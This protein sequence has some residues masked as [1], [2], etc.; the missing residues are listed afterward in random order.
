MTARPT[1]IAAVCAAA[2]LL[3]S[4][5]AA[6]GFPL[7][8][9]GGALPVGSEF[10]EEALDQP[11]E[12]FK[13]EEAGGKR[14]YLLN[15]GDMAFSSPAIFG[16][17][18]RQA[19]LSCNSCHQGGAGNPALFMPG[20]STR[21][22]NF[23]VSG[24]LF[25][26][27]ADNGVLDPVRPPS[28]RG[29]RYLAP[30]GH[31][32]RFASLRDFVRNVIV[33]EFAGAEPSPEVL[34]GLIAYLEEIQFLP[35]KKLAP[36]GRLSAAAGA[37]ARRGEAVFN[38]PFPGDASL[39]CGSCHDRT[40][41]FVDHRMHD[42]GTG[43]MVKTP[44]LINANLN[45]PYFHDA[46]FDSYEQVVDYFDKFYSL[47]LGKGDRQDLIAYLRAVGDADE[48]TTRNTLTLEL[49]EIAQFASTLD[50]AVARRDKA[51]VSLAVASVGGEWRELTEKF[52]PRSDPT[53]SGGVKE[54]LKARATIADIVLQLRRIEM[55]VDA[56]DFAAGARL[57]AD[58][59]RSV[60]AATPILLAAEPFS[61][62]DPAVHDAH[63]RALE[64]LAKA[65]T[66]KS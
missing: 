7:Q 44:T 28:M 48:P 30:Y 6:L 13:S 61:L 64:R 35:N 54:R 39:S 45:A 42:V 38:R 10:N 15:L 36:G 60:A 3:G 18:A 46:R 50:V 63:F 49:D 65:A 4:A 34:D 9:K 22:G 37:A 5:G 66:P 20:M 12:L 47:R 27:P 25:N 2:F 14:S 33:N 56:G 55:T 57:V 31:D 62:F 53:A 52:P 59:H 40:A 21:P 8:D 43:G 16:G 29:I 58:Y 23:D 19:G 11:T 32:G 26:P 24:P 17:V 41:A 1:G 51:I